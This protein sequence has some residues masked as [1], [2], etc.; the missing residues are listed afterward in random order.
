MGTPADADARRFAVTD[1]RHPVF[2]PLDDLV[3]ALG[4]VRFARTARVSFS[5]P[6]DPADYSA[7]VLARF[8]HGDAALVEF[9]LG[10]GRALVF[11]SDLNMEANDLPRHPGFVP[12]L[13][14]I[15][16]YLAG[17]EASASDVLP[18][19]APPGVP[20]VPGVTLDP[21]SGRSVAV[22]VDPRESES[23]SLT[24]DGFLARLDASSPAAFGVRSMSGEVAREAEQ[25]L[26]WYVVLAMAVVLAGEA[27]LGR[28]M[29]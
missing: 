6:G 13:Q 14:E 19:G 16:R 3:P 23:R 1:P 10:T 28:N 15:V 2:R 22:N 27:W 29:A 17:P 7:S 20:R 4:R 26:W 25:S 8:D 21:L 12:L 24:P 9:D 11:A 5:D 18:A